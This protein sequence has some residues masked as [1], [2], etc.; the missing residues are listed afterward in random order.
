M[1]IFLAAMVAILSLASCS[2][3]NK[4]V[5][6][7]DLQ[8]KYRM[9]VKYMEKPDYDRAMPLLEELLGLTR[10]DTLYEQVS[11]YYA[12]GYFGM[13]DYI[14][15]SYYLGHFAKMFPNSEH[16]QECSFL[17]ALC[18]YK[19][20]PEFELDQ[21][22]T[23]TAIEKLELFMVRYPESSLRDSCITLIDQLRLKLEKKDYAAAKQYLRTRHYEA[24]GEALERFVRKWPN[25]MYREE[26]LYSI[27]KARH[28][29]A[30]NSVE[31]KLK[32]RVQAGIRSFN[33][34]A[35]AFPE[36]TRMAQA[37]N[38]LRDL[39]MLKIRSQGTETP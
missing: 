27:L 11:Y 16:A 7:T 24:A 35:D 13:K 1:R 19:E 38:M 22:D 5:K 9:A 3:F 8:Y 37:R 17:S 14:M 15:A 10:G 39:D 18:H 20:S 36:S 33:T 30:M 25:S 31:A 28:D 23:R 4:A 29:L 12:K 26:A 34:F 2:E 21:R 6:S 32:D